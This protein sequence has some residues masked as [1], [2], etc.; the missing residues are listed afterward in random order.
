MQ[1]FHVGSVHFATLGVLRYVE[2]EMDVRLLY[3]RDGLHFEPADRSRPFLAP[4]G[5]GYWDA[6]MVS[7]TSQ[8]VEMGDEWWFYHGGTTSHH[9]WWIGPPDGVDEPEV[10]D[11]GQ[12]VRYSLGLAKLRKEG[13]ASLDGSR[14]REGYVITRPL[15][16][17]GTR[18]VVN[19]RCR[20]GGSI[21]AAVFGFDNQP[22]GS[23][24][25][26]RATSLKEIAQIILSPGKVHRRYRAWA[27][28]ASWRSSSEIPRYFRLGSMEYRSFALI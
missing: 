9:D 3:S 27:N 21:R 18:L 8:P 4:R 24:H 6:H 25:W 14:Q 15:M 28:G 11:P 22:M 16:S 26:S 2:N 20:P 10:H 19:A 23:T 12:H 13:V 17:N 5:E 1:Q 7:M